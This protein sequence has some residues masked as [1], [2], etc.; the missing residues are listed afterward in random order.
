MSLEE[1]DFGMTELA[2]SGNQGRYQ[3]DH[4]LLVRFFMHPKLDRKKSMEEERPIYHETVYISIMQPGNKESIIMRPAMAMDKT[5][6]AEHYKKF[7]AREDQD[8]VDGTQLEEWPAITRSQMQELRFFNVRTVEQLV[9]I[10]DV[11]AQRIM[12]YGA[13]KAKALEFLE[14]AATSKSEAE[15]EAKLAKRDDQIAALLARVEA[16]ESGEIEEVP[17]MVGD[18]D[19]GGDDIGEEEEKPPIEEPPAAKAPARKRRRAK[20]AA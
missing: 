18:T 19:L 16:M 9:N 12:G 15:L 4:V 2:M 3:G 10:S 20:K 6:F 8:A 5:R 11:N 13:L 17:A 1:A 14:K 7:K